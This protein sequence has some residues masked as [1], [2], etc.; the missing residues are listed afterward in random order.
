MTDGR[1]DTYIFDGSRYPD[2]ERMPAINGRSR[3]RRSDGFY[4][5]LGIL[6]LLS[7]T[8]VWFWLSG[9]LNA[10]PI[11]LYAMIAVLVIVG[12]IVYSTYS[13]ENT[14]GATPG[15]VPSEGIISA[16]RRRWNCSEVGD[17]VIIGSLGP[18]QFK[19]TSGRS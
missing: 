11:Y 6:V 15:R 5:G 14:V 9:D 2:L 10:E 8:T 18:V 7:A 1:E 4:E 12:I 16:G 19:D 13:S 17:L 3:R